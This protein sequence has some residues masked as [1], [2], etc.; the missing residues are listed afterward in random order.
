MTTI[1]ILLSF[2]ASLI[3]IEEPLKIELWNFLNT[4]L[5][6]V[7]AIA[8]LFGLAMMIFFRRRHIVPSA[9]SVMLGTLGI[10]I[11]LFSEH[12]GIAY[13]STI[14]G[15]PESLRIAVPM[16]DD[17]IVAWGGD[18][19]KNNYHTAYPDQRW[20]YDLV[21][22]P[23]SV[24][25]HTLEDYGC[26]GKTVFAPISG[27]IRTAHDGEADIP[28]GATYR[29]SNVFGNYI[30]IQPQGKET[31]L[32]LAH[33]KKGSL[34]VE[35]GDLI[36]EGQ[37]IA[38]CGNSGSST[39]P[40]LHIHLI[41]IVESGSRTHLIGQPLYFRDHSGSAMPL[42]GIERRNGKAVIIGEKIHDLSR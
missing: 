12:I 32:V 37:P 21:T 39:E 38:E 14:S 25:S 30:V 24:R 16:N 2:Y 33:L 7:A 9:M 10:I 22:E 19:A 3:Y 35:K 18:S 15:S 20:A 29:G 28:P 36:I 5:P 8:L 31:R 26:Y 27:E 6:I 4:V 17:V 13:P 34:S 23:Y 41:N 1:L 11:G 40:H 42:G